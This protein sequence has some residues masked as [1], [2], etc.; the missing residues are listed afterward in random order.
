MKKNIAIIGLFLMLASVFAAGAADF[1]NKPIRMIVPWSA[2]GGSDVLARTFQ[3][4]FE[5]ALGQRVLIENIPAGATVVGTMELMKSKPDGYTILFSNEAWITRYYAK[6][7]TEKVWEKMTPIANITSEPLACIEVRADSPYKTY[8]DL[9]KAIRA[10]PGKI[11]CGNPGVGS[12]L[13]I[14]FDAIV[15]A[16]GAEVRYVPFS[17]G[18]ASKTAML[19]GHVDFR[20][21]QPTEAI[22]SVKG[23]QSRV[24][25]VCNDKRIEQ[26]PGVPTFKEVGMNVDD[27]YKIIRGV[28]GPPGLPADLTDALS[29]FCETASR[30][31]AFV[32]AA[33]KLSYTVDY[34]NSK[35]VRDFVLGFDKQFGPLLKKIMGD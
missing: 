9:L 31:A 21:C 35:Q 30:D 29:K 22:P 5:K 1:P 17:G 34:R 19:G 11:T 15:N 10:N 27:N 33:E 13:D 3:P 23:G 24:L 4:A 25:A 6:T 18:G 28:W 2:G 20:V 16:A 8:E 26:L 7:Y 32:Q 12:P 14:A